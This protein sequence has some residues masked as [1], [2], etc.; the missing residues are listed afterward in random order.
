MS[1]SILYWEAPLGSVARQKGALYQ[2]HSVHVTCYCLI[3]F[4]ICMELKTLKRLQLCVLLYE[5]L[6]DHQHQN[7]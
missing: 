3:K 1:L 2:M 5:V 7:Q 6:I 4:E